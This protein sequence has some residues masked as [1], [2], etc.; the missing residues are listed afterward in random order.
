[1]IR[2]LKIAR[3]GLQAADDVQVKGWYQ[4]R[5]ILVNLVSLIGLLLAQFG[6]LPVPWPEE[7]TEELAAAILTIVNAVTIALR[8]DTDKPV[9][10]KT[11][12]APKPAE[13]DPDNP[14]DDQPAV[15]EGTETRAER[16]K[17]LGVGKTTD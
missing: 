7:Q 11:I 9:G 14:P 6:L 2:W 5:L 3:R 10:R 17:R 16:R 8:F 12:R 4:S 15:P 1:M 13:D